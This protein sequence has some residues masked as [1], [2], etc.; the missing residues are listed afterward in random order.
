MEIINKLQKEILK[1][2]SKSQLRKKFYWTG[3]TALSFIYLKHRRSDDLDF[4][5]N[6]EFF[7]KDIEPFIKEIEREL[8][9]K[10]LDIK[11]IDGRYEILITNKNF[12]KIDFNYYPYPRIANS[13]IYKNITVDSIKDIAAN[14]TL[15]LFDR[16]EPKD[17]FDLYFIIT[18]KNIKPKQ[19]LKLVEN[20]FKLKLSED[21]FW[22]EALKSLKQIKSL[23]P[24][25]IRT[26]NKEL[27]LNKIENFFLEN[28]A[29][30][31]KRYI[32]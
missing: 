28:S 21:I 2:F 32:K 30:Y 17:L 4:F 24:Y 27:L 19:L 8:K 12:C 25:I 14:K 16:N 3:G 29:S 6:N 26:K 9:P 23:K 13:K 18:K 20:K 10:K 31:L 22:S 7:L 15:S 1:L 5:T 11:K